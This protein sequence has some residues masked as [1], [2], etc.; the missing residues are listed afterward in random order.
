MPERCLGN[1]GAAAVITAPD[2][3]IDGDTSA[4]HDRHQSEGWRQL[5]EINLASIRQLVSRRSVRRVVTS[6]GDDFGQLVRTLEFGETP[7][8]CN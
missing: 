4:N 3:G 8:K 1:M 7:G 2:A 6:R 5:E